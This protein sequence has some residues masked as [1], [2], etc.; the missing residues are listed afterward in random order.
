MTEALIPYLLLILL[1][2]SDLSP[3]E[4]RELSRRIRNGDHGAFKSFFDAHHEALHRFLLSKG[5]A[6]EAADDLIQKAFIYIW[7]HR[8]DIDPDKSL[9]AY[10][11]RIGYTRMLNHIRYRKK[12]DDSP[13]LPPTESADNPAANMAAGQLKEA[14]EKAIANM[15]EKRGMVFE[16]CFIQEFTYRETANALDISIKTVENHMALA[17]KD[18]RE[19]LKEYKMLEDH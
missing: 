14:I 12:F 5:I 17:L 18:M 7:E 1:S 9:R 15:P 11:F 4:A 13:E 8:H 6:K 2:S 10:L 19:A 3:Q 16:M